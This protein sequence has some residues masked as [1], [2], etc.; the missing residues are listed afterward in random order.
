MER[1]EIL[2]RLADLKPWLASQGVGRVRLFG[3][4]PRDAARPDSDIDLL[5][6]LSRPLGL[7]F[8]ALKDELGRRL[9]PRLT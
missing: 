3:S 7:A 2:R 6:D 4:H 8:F 9:A 1:R 5:V